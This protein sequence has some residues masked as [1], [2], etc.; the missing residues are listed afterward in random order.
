MGD[1]RLDYTFYY[2]LVEGEL[3]EPETVHSFR[4]TGFLGRLRSSQ[5]HGEFLVD[6]ECDCRKAL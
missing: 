1:G 6:G 2:V 4:R 5:S 3:V